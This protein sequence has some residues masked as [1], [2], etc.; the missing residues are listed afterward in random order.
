MGDFDEGWKQYEYRWKKK[1]IAWQ[2]WEFKQPVWRG[3]E[4]LRGKTVL[5]LAEQGLGDTLNFIR[6][7]PL[8]ADRGATVI[9]GVQKPLKDLAADGA[10][11]LRAC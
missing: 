1:G 7:A 9:V 11:R 10:R 5:L 8:V 3:K 2:P 6:D 4:D